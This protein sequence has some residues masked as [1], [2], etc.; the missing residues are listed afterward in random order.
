[1]LLLRAAWILGFV[2]TDEY[3]SRARTIRFGA[4]VPALTD[5]AL[6]K[7][8]RSLASDRL[9]VVLFLIGAVLLVWT[10]VHGPMLG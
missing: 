8:E 3:Q 9:A 10:C 5:T 1:M 4:G 2:S 6:R 7:L